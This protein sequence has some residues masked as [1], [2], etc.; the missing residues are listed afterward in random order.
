MSLYKRG[1]VYWSA[2]WIDGVREMRSLETSNRRRAEQ[3]EQQF[4]DEL[5]TRRFQLPDL[6]SSVGLSGNLYV[7]RRTLHWRRRSSLFCM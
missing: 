5:H 2:I 7:R 6:T 3:L 4:K 1:K